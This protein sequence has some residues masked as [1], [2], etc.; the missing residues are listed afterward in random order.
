MLTVEAK[1]AIAARL[2]AAVTVGEDDAIRA[3][4]DLE[5]LGIDSGPCGAATLAGV[6]A[7]LRDIRARDAIGPD[8]TILLLSTE[9]R[10]ANPLPSG[11]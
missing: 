6:R 7:L 1:D 3:V 2:D 4:H 10:L 9:A 8:A 5:A 11:R